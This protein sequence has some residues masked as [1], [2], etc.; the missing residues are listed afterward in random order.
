MNER[1]VLDTNI[2]IALID[3]DSAVRDHIVAASD[4]FIPSPALGELYFGAFR[5]RRPE[6]NVALIDDLARSYAVLPVD[7]GTARIFGKLQH[8]LRSSGN[9]IPANDV[10]IAAIAQQWTAT[11]ATRDDH[12]ARLRGVSVERW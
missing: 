7:G 3:G 2:V 11:V 1:F 12:F 6:K 10:W 5:S 9:P 8:D 4:I